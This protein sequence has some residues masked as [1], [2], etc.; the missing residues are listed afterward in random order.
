MDTRVGRLAPLTGILFVVLYVAGFALTADS[1]EFMAR[2]A[3]NLRYYVEHK[4]D[5]I[6]AGVL[7]LLAFGL[8]LW[9]LGSV[10]RVLGAAEGG[11]HRVT[12]I[13]FGAGTVGAALMLAG[14]VAFVLPALRLDERDR[15]DSVSATVMMDLGSGLMGIAAALAF[16]VALIAVA[17]VGV[18]N[19]A[20]PQVW[21]WITALLG[22]VMVVPMISWF[23]VFFL[24]P[25]WILVTAIL[26][27]LGQR[28]ANEA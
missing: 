26:L 3:E 19:R 13:A 7:L 22:V 12:A 10:R 1:P 2:P 8:L 4:S 25:L 15:L 16:G 18:R 28:R 17:V 5:V 27:L 14:V 9:F 23:G 21:A 11:D 6:V 20:L 24:F